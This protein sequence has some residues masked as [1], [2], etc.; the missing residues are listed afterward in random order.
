MSPTDEFA[1][2]EAAAKQYSIHDEKVLVADG[3]VAQGG[4]F[5]SS[6]GKALY[7]ADMYN[8]KKIMLGWP[9]EWERYRDIGR[10][11]NAK[12]GE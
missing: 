2:L 12:R 3:M 4:G 6:L 8:T 9:D 10:K 11:L 5:I 7:H 1:Q